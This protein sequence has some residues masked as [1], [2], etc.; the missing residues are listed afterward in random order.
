MFVTGEYLGHIIDTCN[1]TS[2][3]EIVQRARIL[4]LNGRFSTKR[5]VLLRN[6]T[7]K[8]VDSVTVNSKTV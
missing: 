1:F 4:L 7:N 3:S 6:G 5:A 8:I 2:L